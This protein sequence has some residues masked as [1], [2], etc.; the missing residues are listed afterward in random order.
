MSGILDKLAEAQEI[1]KEAVEKLEQKSANIDAKIAELEREAAKVKAAEADIA[2]REKEVARAKDIIE[3]K[4]TLD[5][6]VAE[7]EQRLNVI[8]TQ[9]KELRASYAKRE[10]VLAVKEQELKDKE[11]DLN[12][13]AKE[14]EVEKT[15]YKEKIIKSFANKLG[16]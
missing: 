2:A 3:T 15:T 7:A 4:D 10:N 16:E 8:E 9:E 6:L 13:R 11:A 1:A 12:R 14:L 5:R